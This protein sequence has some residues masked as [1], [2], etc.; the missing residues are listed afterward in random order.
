LGFYPIAIAQIFISF[1]LGFQYGFMWGIIEGVLI[2]SKL[3]NKDAKG[4]PLK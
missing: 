3:I 2:I 4:R 1:V